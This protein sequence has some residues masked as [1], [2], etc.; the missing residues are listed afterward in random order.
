MRTIIYV[1]I[2]SMLFFVPLEP[3]EIARLLP[4]ETVA[5]YMNDGDVVHFLF[6]V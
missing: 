6:N 3:V 2:L 4:I 1:V 5:V